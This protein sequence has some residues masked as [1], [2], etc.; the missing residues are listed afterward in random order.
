MGKLFLE[1]S[2]V[3]AKHHVVLPSELMMFFKSM[4]T[5]EGLARLVREDFDMLPFVQEFAK[6]LIKTKVTTTELFSDVSFRMK[7]WSSLL[8]SLPKE[9]KTHLRKINHPDYA[10]SIEIKGVRDIQKT[11]YQ[12]GRLVFIGIVV[13]ALT[14]AG[15][16]TID[17][18]GGQMIY[19]FPLLSMIMFS[20]AGLL[21]IRFFLKNR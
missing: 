20:L 10:E 4:V 9:L 19:G 2:R 8:E 7:E 15:A 13:A 6:D 5:I 21:F 1:S 17:H 3:A 18:E 11:V 16:M 12:T 14:I